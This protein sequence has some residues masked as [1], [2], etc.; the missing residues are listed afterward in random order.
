MIATRSHN[1]YRAARG[2]TLQ[3]SPSP[4][5]GRKSI[6][7]HIPKYQFGTIGIFP[8]EKC[9]RRAAHCTKLNRKILDTTINGAYFAGPCI[10]SVYIV[11]P[12]RCSTLGG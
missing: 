12:C 5:N 11:A 9:G 6:G 10:N 4:S 1:T 3:N 2:V 8:T 7:L